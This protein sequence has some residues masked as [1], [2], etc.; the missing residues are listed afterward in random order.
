MIPIDYITEWRKHAPWVFDSQVEQD[1]VICRALIGLYSSP[2]LSS[3]VIFRG[4]T[5]L[6]KLHS[7][8][9]VRYSEDIDLVQARPGPI[10]EIIDAIRS[11]LDP[12]LGT[13]K[14]NVKE[15]TVNLIYRFT[16]EGKPSTS[17]RLKVEINTRE[18]F[19]IR[20]I[21]KSEYS[22]Q[23]RWFTGSTAISTYAINELLGTKFRALFQRKKGRDLFDL[24]YFLENAE[25]DCNDIVQ[26]F[27]QYMGFSGST[28]TRAVFEKNLFQKLRDQAFLNDT[29]NFLVS[30]LNWDP[31][32][33]AKKVGD[34]LISLLPGEPWKGEEGMQ[35]KV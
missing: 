29:R 8:S 25:A 7:K 10:G 13:P 16:S 30:D 19:A 35:N 34:S 1:L 5:A 23:S 12:W 2:L 14:R 20:P 24:W 17:L 32:V 26:C 18:H 21:S 11:T 33:A 9:P 28:V 27:T 22:V 15:G 6:Y 3:S 4:G 31:L